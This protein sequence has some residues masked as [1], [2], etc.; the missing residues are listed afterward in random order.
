MNRLENRVFIITGAASGMGQVTT[1]KFISEGAKV[2]AVDISEKVMDMWKEQ[3]NVMPIVV[4][5]T[6]LEDIQN[7]IKK[8]KET[9]GKLDGVCNI[10]GINDLSY[11]LLETDDQR[12]DKVM[13][14]DLKAPFRILREAIPLMIEN[15]SGAIVNI[16]SYAAIRGNHGPSYTAAKAGL[17]GLTKSIAFS[18]AKHN[19]RCN[20]I[21]PGGCATHLTLGGL[22]YHPAQNDLSNLIK[23]MPVKSFN[24]PDHIADVCCF[25]C[26]DEASWINGAEISVDGGMCTC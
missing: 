3:E 4:D 15:G 13:E 2:I 18:Y 22:A 17:S 9:F 16:G 5:V 8:T 23:A 21:H 20:I 12:W 14:L 24:T 7:L 6:K 10:A 25:L 1:A 19:I 11:P 26:S